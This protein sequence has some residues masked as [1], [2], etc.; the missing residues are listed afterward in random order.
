MFGLNERQLHKN[1]LEHNEEGCKN[2]IF[3]PNL[4]K[5][6]RH[7]T[8]EKGRGNIRK[9]SN[10]VEVETNKQT[11]KRGGRRTTGIDSKMK[12]N[13]EVAST[14]CSVDFLGETVKTV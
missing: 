7:S 11:K 1:I 6:Q 5:N 8:S 4:T 14:A 10:I 12:I 2:L 9:Q 3:H 13:F